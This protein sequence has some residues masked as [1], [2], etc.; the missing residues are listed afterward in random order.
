MSMTTT[1]NSAALP[2]VDVKIFW[3]TLAERVT[4]ITIVTAHGEDGPA[5]L[6]GLSAAHVTADPPTILNSINKEATALS[7]ILSRRTSR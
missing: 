1:I 2:P 6:L 5:G 4:G 3:Q 7:A